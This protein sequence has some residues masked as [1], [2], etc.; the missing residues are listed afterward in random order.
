MRLKLVA[1]TY[2]LWFVATE[3]L[4]YAVGEEQSTLAI[5]VLLGLIPA[6]MQLLILGFNS[7]GAA[8]PLRMV[9]CFLLIV[10]LSYLGNAY[11]TSLI[12]L[13]ALVFVFLIAILV[14]SSPDERLIRNIAIYYSIPTALLLLYVSAT[15]K[16]DWGRLEANG[17][18]PNWFG[19]ISVGLAMAGLAH[20]S[21]LLRALC[22][23]VGLYVAYDASSRE[24]LLSILCGLLAVGALELRALPGR[25]LVLALVMSAAL[26]V[27]AIVLRRTLAGDI[28]TTVVSVMHLNDPYRGLGTGF[29]GRT[30][31][32]REAIQV[33]LKSPW[34]GVGFHQHYLFMPYQSEA[35]EVYLAMLADTGIFGLIWYVSFLVASLYAAAR[36]SEPRLRNA[37]IGMISAYA[38]AGFFDARGL[39]SG[40]PTSL[41]FEMCCVFA[42]RH[43]SIQRALRAWRWRYVLRP[44]H[45]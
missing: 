27:L 10:L 34:F 22:I 6:A 37:A 40:N 33:W 29:T 2:A 32:W 3:F 45:G 31:I 7:Y 12:W 4:F 11:W 5:G 9:L 13:A 17:I 15:G 16:H 35:H 36:I 24:S 43:A 1:V 38:V 8:G 25:R 18:Q 42:L 20:Q 26:L 41:Y 44:E 19:L 14:A 21:R 39:G 28:T 23:G 30:T